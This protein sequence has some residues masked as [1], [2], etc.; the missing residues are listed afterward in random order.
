VRALIGLGNLED[1]G[2]K[3]I[4][5]VIHYTFSSIVEATSDFSNKLGEGG[6]GPIYKVIGSNSFNFVNNQGSI[7]SQCNKF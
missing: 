1:H 5:G 7:L 2:S 6:Y 4:N 3:N